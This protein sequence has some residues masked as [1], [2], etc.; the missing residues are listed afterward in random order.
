MLLTPLAQ[1]TEPQQRI[2][3]DLFGLLKTEKGKKCILYMTDTFT[4]YAEMVAIPNNESFTMATTIFERRI[5]RFGVPLEIITDQGKEFCAKVTKDLFQLLQ[6]TH[7]TSTAYHP[8]CNSQAE[9]A[10][11]TIAK[12]L[13]SYV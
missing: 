9:V 12:Y 8:Q 2:H 4:K 3:A 1:C 7:S 5:C 13:S 11:T 6:I 10:N